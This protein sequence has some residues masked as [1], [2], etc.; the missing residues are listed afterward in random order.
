MTFGL[1]GNNGVR[2][3]STEAANPPSTCPACESSVIKT[4][5]KRPNADSYWRCENCG[6]VWN[7]SRRDDRRRGAGRWR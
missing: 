1:Y 7:A 6:E 3:S 5:T 2:R 4:T